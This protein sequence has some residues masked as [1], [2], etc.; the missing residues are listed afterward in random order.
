M[1]TRTRHSAEQRLQLLQAI[2]QRL[3]AD[4]PLKQI[5]AG[6]VE[7]LREA[8][9]WDYV[10]CASVDAAA[11]CLQFE[12]HAS[13]VLA[14]EFGQQ[15]P[16]GDGIVGEVA[17]SG[18]ALRIDDVLDRR[19]FVDMVPGTRAE[20]CVPVIHQGE[21]IA[22]LDAQSS[23]VAAFTAED[24]A[25]LSLV[26]E[27]LAGHMAAVRQLEAA[28][29]RADL[30]GLL[31]EVSRAMLA[32]DDLDGMLQRLIDELYR[33]FDLTLATLCL[34][35]PASKE[36]VLRAFAGQTAYPL[37]CGRPWPRAHGITGRAMRHGKRVFVPDVR[38]DPDYIE[39]NPASTAE[40]VVPIRFRGEPLGFINLESP[41]AARFSPANQLAVQAL[42]DQVAGSIRL[43]VT[44]HAL[45]KAN[46]VASAAGVELARSN[47][48]LARAN[49]KLEHLNLSDALTGLGNRRCFDRALRER[50]R[51]LG[52]ERRS[53]ALLL[54][55]IDHYK[56][57][58][59]HYGHSQGD[60]CLQRLA[61]LL[62]RC[63]RSGEAV[64]ARYGGEEFAILLNDVGVE[65]AVAIAERIHAGLARLA[66]PHAASPTAPYLTCS[67]GIAAEVPQPP[68]EAGDLVR[69]ADA[70]LYAAKRGGRNRSVVS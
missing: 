32:E 23:Q 15:L 44:L 33:C 49:R 13:S 69:S 2:A 46:A 21:V 61:R 7:T 4:R 20:L 29:E 50:W 25:T 57:Y 27:L 8:F 47:R 39:G 43:A 19:N 65:R 54:L 22:V 10:G 60:V 12:A 18:T 11:A 31:A 38:L 3:T 41:S 28:R 48:S 37:Q 67:I 63:C 51:Q 53:L 42:A 1:P 24:Q 62:R 45:E 52:R 5:L 70:A 30:I 36:L 66:L 55:D 34:V 68:R 40:L 59:D 14:L 58:N 16:L 35:D 56:A 9:D 17:L 6:V 26:A 64:L